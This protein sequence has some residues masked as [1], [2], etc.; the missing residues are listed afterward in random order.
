MPSIKQ[1]T[2]Q[3]KAA[4]EAIKG[5]V[6]IVRVLLALGIFIIFGILA[7]VFTTSKLI[8]SFPIMLACAAAT[9]VLYLALAIQYNKAKTSEQEKKKIGAKNA[10]GSIIFM[11]ILIGLVFFGLW[12]FFW[13]SARFPFTIVSQNDQGKMLG[14]IIIA[15]VVYF[16]SMPFIMALWYKT[17][18]GI[19][20]KL[21]VRIFKAFNWKMKTK[22]CE[23]M[24]I[25]TPQEH[26]FM[27]TFKRA[28][29]SLIYSLTIVFSL[30][31][32]LMTQIGGMF[33][34][35]F[36][37]ELQFRPSLSDIDTP[38][39]VLYCSSLI[40]HTVLP[41]VA[42]FVLFFW[43]LPSAYLLDDVGVVYY[44]KYTERRQPA[45][46][47]S[48]SQWFSSLVQAVLGTSALIT[49]MTF[50]YNNRFVVGEIFAAVDNFSPGFF[51]GLCATMFSIFIFGFPIIGTVL[52]AY[53]LLL[54]Q[55]SQ[56]NKLKTHL[57]QEL[58]NAKIDPR[59][60][61]IEFERKDKF[62]ER[63]LLN[64]TGENFFH[65]PP[66]KDS[67]SKFAPAGDIDIKDMLKK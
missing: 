53:I 39:F 1:L 48:V 35:G 44:K 32:P 36:G 64:Y 55:E 67:I 43:T 51:A 49:Y 65:N 33:P 21:I 29:T 23:L 50:I 7:I 57:F 59:I 61:Q 40:F 12:F 14:A 27:I 52:M 63:T 24:V 16:A 30:W 62:Q 15:V 66:L 10:I 9:F 13:L 60:V 11:L 58:V 8:T 45:E 26:S 37:F 47:R 42:T 22:A 18:P 5:R 46:L 2:E 41:V 4:K 25:E 56:F 54:F 34:R 28:F 31:H 3:R 38:G 20:V 6:P 19:G 17:A